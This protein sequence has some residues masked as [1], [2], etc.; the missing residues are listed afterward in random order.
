M[1]TRRIRQLPPV[2][3]LYVAWLLTAGKLVRVTL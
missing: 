1:T 2:G 3:S